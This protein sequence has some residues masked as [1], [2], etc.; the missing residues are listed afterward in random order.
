MP[1]SAIPP[2]SYMLF[3]RRNPYN[4]RFQRGSRLPAILLR[5]SESTA[6]HLR[7]PA[8]FAST[9]MTLGSGT[10]ADGTRPASNSI[11]RGSTDDFPVEAYGKRDGPKNRLGPADAIGD[12]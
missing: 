10:M 12:R 8:H 4:L 1:T 11:I 3:L 2:Q 7:C 9:R 6:K 5:T